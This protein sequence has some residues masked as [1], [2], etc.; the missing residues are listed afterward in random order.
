MPYNRFMDSPQPPNAARSALFGA[1]LLLMAAT[2]LWMW[3]AYDDMPERMA[4]HFDGRDRPNGWSTKGFFYIFYP[5]MV[6]GI[7]LLYVVIM[8]LMMR[9]LPASL[10]NLPNKDYWF[11]SEHLRQVALTRIDILMGMTTLFV[12]AIFLYV[13]AIVYSM[14]L[15][16]PPQWFPI[17][18]SLYI[19][20]IGTGFYIAGLLGY[21]FLAF[22]LPQ[23]TRG[24]V[25]T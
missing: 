17:G 18:K 19:I 9:R 1:S 4:T 21:V 7:N 25:R 15:P 23:N 3:T 20:F 5:L 22:R 24:T 13:F 14:N 10:F 16:S 8:P 12:N 2:M 11:S 6:G